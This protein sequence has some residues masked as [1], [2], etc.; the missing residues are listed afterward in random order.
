MSERK[1][2]TKAKV[3]KY[4]SVLSPSLP[5]VSLVSESTNNSHFEYRFHNDL[6]HQSLDNLATSSG[7][8]G[9][10]SK[11]KKSI[12]TLMSK[13]FQMFSPKTQ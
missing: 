9:L 5:N 6:L 11:E 8:Y 4:E 13:L 2:K 1:Y 10:S 3:L 12:G 7:S